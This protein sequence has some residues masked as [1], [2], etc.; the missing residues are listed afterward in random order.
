MDEQLK[1]FKE[2]GYVV[3]HGALT[4]EEVERV[5]DGIDAD[6][7]AHP[8]EWV[9]R[10]R[11]GHDAVGQSAPELLHRT[12][13]LD[14]VIH[15]PLAVPLVR[16]IL[17]EGVQVSGLSFMRREACL[18]DPPDELDGGD[19]TVLSRQWHRE[20]SGNVEG[21]DKN[22]Y[23]TPAIQIIYYLDDVDETTHC[24]TLIPE[25]AET[26]RS[27]PKA[28]EGDL[29]ID[30]RETSYVDPDKPRWM[31]AFGREN[32][33]RIGGV[34]VF[35]KAGTAV[36]FNNAN[37]HCGTIRRT[38]QIRRT[39]HVR[40]RQPEPVSSRHAIVDPWKSVA[41][42]QGAMPKRSSIGLI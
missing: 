14:G 33:R 7:R 26:K 13:A 16:S 22:D 39:V 20:D 42:F 3:L 9:M 1:H 24:T 30:D 18:A 10:P 5:N 37:W 12:E 21:A 34:N 11:P 31:D 40:Y 8:E 15:H 28:T 27:L 29:R 35:G 17:G 38:E 4:P 6:A 32:P 41:D 23:F 19:P 25:R 2:N 36:V